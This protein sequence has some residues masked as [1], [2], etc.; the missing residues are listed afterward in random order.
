M[1]LS[2]ADKLLALSQWKISSKMTMRTALK[3]I[4]NGQQL[5]CS[6]QSAAEIA[7]MQSCQTYIVPGHRHCF[8]I[9]GLAGFCKLWLRLLNIFNTERLFVST[10]DFI[11]TLYFTVKWQAHLKFQYSTSCS[12]PLQWDRCLTTC[13]FSQRGFVSFLRHHPLL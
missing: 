9:L 10:L 8:S 7:C 3:A 4:K 13:I 12:R 1:V 2:D 5:T 11:C 6:I